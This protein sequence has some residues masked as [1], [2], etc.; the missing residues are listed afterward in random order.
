MALDENELIELEQLI[1]AAEGGASP[2]TELRRRFPH[3]A[4]VQCDASDVT[5]PSFR[6][7]PHFDLHLLDRSDHCVQIT[8]DPLLATG[9]VLAARGPSE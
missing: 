8:A 4:L 6:S 3:L 2:F 1:T 5:E 9:I 7:F